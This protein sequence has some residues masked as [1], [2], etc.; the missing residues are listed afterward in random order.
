MR[1]VRLLR[2]WVLGLGCLLSAAGG[3][4]A[5]VVCQKGSK[6]SL[7]AETCKTTET[8]VGVLA[9]NDPT[10]IWEFDSGTLFDVTELSPRFLVLESAGTGQL[11]SSGGDGGVITC[12]SLTYATG[13]NSTLVLELP[14]FESDG[15]R[16]H[17]YQISGGTTLDLTG[18]DGRS[19]SFSR[20]TAVDPADDCETLSQTAE[21]TGLPRHSFFSGLAFDGVS[22]QYEEENTENVIPVDPATGAAGAPVSIS[23][24]TQFVHVH[25]SQGANYWTHCGCGG[26]PEAGLVTP[27]GT[28]LDEVQTESELNDEISVRAIAFDPVGGFLWLHGTN[29]AGQGRLLKVDASGEPDALVTAFDLDAELSGLAFDGTN[30]WGV[31]RPGQSVVRIDP[32][33]GQATGNFLVPNRDASWRGIAVVGSELAL[34]GDTGTEGRILKVTRP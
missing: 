3:A 14:S 26:S 25:A 33:T 1:F 2:L 21:F 6:V 29:N 18:A 5:A 22:L 15:S 27:T 9:G 32:A 4:S 20:A 17:P 8:Q 23:G 19:A 7:R 31:N 30:L 12:A 11:N 28:L 34:V 13:A 24:N 10:G 16:V